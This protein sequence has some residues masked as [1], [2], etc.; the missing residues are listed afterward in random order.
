YYYFRTFA[1]GNGITKIFF[2]LVMVLPRR[3]NTITM[4]LVILLPRQGNPITMRLVIG[5]PTR[6]FFGNLASQTKTEITKIKT[7]FWKTKTEI[8][9]E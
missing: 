1:V 9:G 6:K 7:P 5:L 3:G 8:F 2:G 4:R